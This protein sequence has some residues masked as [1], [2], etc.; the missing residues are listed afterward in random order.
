[1]TLNTT[2]P[3]SGL[4][5]AEWAV[6]ERLAECHSLMSELDGL[7]FT[8]F[9]NAIQTLQEQVLALPAKRAL[10]RLHHEPDTPPQ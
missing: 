1:M 4:T 10:A 2:T 7:D 8:R 3:T 9:D 5:E 6:V